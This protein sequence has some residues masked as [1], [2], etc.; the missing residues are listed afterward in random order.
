MKDTEALYKQHE[1]AVKYIQKIGAPQYHFRDGSVGRLSSLS[2]TTEI[3]HQ[4][5]TGYNNHW[6]DSTFDAALSLAVKQ[7][8][9]MLAEQALVL[10]KNDADNSLLEEKEVLKA[11]LKKIEELENEQPSCERNK[12]EGEQV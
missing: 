8:F 1:N 6:K 12:S 11:R 9:Q 2:V 10:M 3:C 5:N 4:Q 7:N